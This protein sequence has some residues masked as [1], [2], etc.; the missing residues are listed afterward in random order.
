M[1]LLAE[2][3]KYRLKAKKRHGIHSP[4]V[5]E[6]SDCVFRQKIDSTSQKSIDDYR[7]KLLNNIQLIEVKDFGAGS[8]KMGNLRKV[9]SIF[10]TSSAGNFGKRLFQLSHFYKPNRILELGTSLGFGS[11]HFALGNPESE[12]VTIEGC[13]NTAEIAKEML[14][15]YPQIE[16]RV[17]QFSDQIPLLEGTFDIIYIDGHHDGLATLKYLKQLQNQIHDETLIIMDDIR[18]SDDMFDAWKTAVNSR[19]W[20]VTVDLFRMGIAVQ[21]KTQV[22]EHFTLRF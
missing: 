22:K 9:S 6:M 16:I 20:H 17:G 5:Y 21:R 8:K 4:F 1:N 3:I 19:D 2:Y 7:N 12:V 11:L 14:I 15:N 13:P 18:W 10:K